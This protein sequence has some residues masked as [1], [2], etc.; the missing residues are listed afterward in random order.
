MV[1]S[2]DDD[3]GSAIVGCYRVRGV[4]AEGATYRV[5]A[6][7]QLARGLALAVGGVAALN[8]MPILAIAPLVLLA[9]AW[10]VF[11]LLDGHPAEGG[12]VASLVAGLIVIDLAIAATAGLIAWVMLRF[13]FRTPTKLTVADDGLIAFRSWWRT[14]EIRPVDV[15]CVESGV[16]IGPSRFSV[17]VRH[18]GGEIA[19][20][21]QFHDF[22]DFLARL[23]VLNP[24]V[25]IKGF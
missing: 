7:I 12:W 1:E 16:W 9:A 23:K 18:K 25:E 3:F 21:N 22:R 8:T 2:I 20:F 14:I 10:T 19:F 5:S 15:H 13:A 11:S 4:L 24:A 6:F 17:V